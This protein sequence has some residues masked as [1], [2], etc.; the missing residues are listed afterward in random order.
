MRCK[1]FVMGWQDVILSRGWRND[2]D[3]CPRMQGRYERGRQFAVWAIATQGE[4]VRQMKTFK[5]GNTVPR[6]AV[7]ALLKA[8]KE[9][10]VL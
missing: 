3:Q 2:Y 4:S 8:H 9:G 5:Q 10:S 6:S 7:K 1:A